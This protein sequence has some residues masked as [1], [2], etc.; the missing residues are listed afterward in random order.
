MDFDKTS[1]SVDWF[2]PG[3]R[4]GPKRLSFPKSA[5]ISID[6]LVSDSPLSFCFSPNDEAIPGPRTHSF[7]DTPF[8]RACGWTNSA[9]PSPFVPLDREPYTM[10]DQH[11][12]AG[13]ESL[14]TDWQALPS[15]G[16]VSITNDCASCGVDFDASC[17]D[18]LDEQLLVSPLECFVELCWAA[19]VHDDVTTPVM[20]KHAR[21]RARSFKCDNERAAVPPFPREYPGS[22]ERTRALAAKITLPLDTFQ[23]F[24]LSPFDSY[25]TSSEEKSPAYVVYPGPEGRPLAFPAAGAQ[26]PRRA[27]K[28]ELTLTPSVDSFASSRHPSTPRMRSCKSSQTLRAISDACATFARAGKR[29]PRVAP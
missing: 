17:L 5:C 25:A 21:T 3:D 10:Y 28:R 18:A 11:S 12:K 29:A 14:T 9:P 24:R 19:A 22:F 23:H 26:M 2:T 8:E 4:H 20:H 15:P 7:V 13:E 1:F 16:L 27:T 6:D